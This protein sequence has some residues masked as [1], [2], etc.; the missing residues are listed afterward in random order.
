L[1]KKFDTDINYKYGLLFILLEHFY[2]N[3]GKIIQTVSIK[4]DTVQY[5]NDN[6]PLYSWANEN[7]DI[8]LKGK[9]TPDELY[10]HYCST[11]MKP[12]K[13]RQFLSK[14]QNI[15]PKDRNTTGHAIYK[16]FIKP[17]ISNQ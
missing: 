1:S 17:L 8:D 9:M 5:L 13:Q 3:K 7:L 11:S 14:I 4:T 6:N 10:K 2:N 16:C 15:V 12:I